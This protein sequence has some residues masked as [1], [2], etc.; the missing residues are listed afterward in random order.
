ME[1]TPL[2]RRSKLTTALEIAVVCSLA[3]VCKC[4]YPLAPAAHRLTFCLRLP[5]YCYEL[6]GAMGLFLNRYILF[7]VGER[8]LFA[9]FSLKPSSFSRVFAAGNDQVM[10]CA[11]L[12]NTVGTLRSEIPYGA[13]FRLHGRKQEKE[14]WMVD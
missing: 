7:E 5:P 10:I 12:P 6:Y 8:K 3:V 2:P 11:T 14:G 13:I 9:L 4:Y 1:A